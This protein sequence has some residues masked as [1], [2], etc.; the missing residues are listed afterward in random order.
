ML[1]YSDFYNRILWQGCL[2]LATIFQDHAGIFKFAVGT[3]Y[4]LHTTFTCQRHKT[5]SLPWTKL[6][7]LL[8]VRTATRMNSVA[9][10]YYGMV[11]FCSNLQA[12]NCNL[13]IHSALHRD[14]SGLSRSRSPFP[15][16]Y[17]H[18]LTLKKQRWLQRL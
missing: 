1:R 14:L 8:C 5:V 4:L 7:V 12:C 16:I 17:N 3:V 13:S 9:C 6:Q 18:I 11:W 10:K 15:L 2:I